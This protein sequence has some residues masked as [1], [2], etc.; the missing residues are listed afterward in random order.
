M[1]YTSEHRQAGCACDRCERKRELSRLYR[2]G[3]RI[4]PPTVT[5]S[6]PKDVRTYGEPWDSMIAA[7]AESSVPRPESPNRGSV[8]AK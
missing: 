6:K 4:N 2:T 3:Q 5:P 1:P 8:K 7:A